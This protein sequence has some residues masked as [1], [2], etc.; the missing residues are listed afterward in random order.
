MSVVVDLRHR[1]VE[2]IDEMVSE[3]HR[4]FGL[5][6][7]AETK[8]H[9]TRVRAATLLS[10]LR[11]RIEAGEEGE[12]VDWWEWYAEKFSRTGRSRK[13]AE[14]L[15]RWVATGDPEGAHEAEKA[16]ARERMR[17]VRGANVRSTK[18]PEA[19]GGHAPPDDEMPT[20]EEADESWQ[21]DVYDHA[22]LLVERMAES[23]RRK[24]IAHVGKPIAA[25]G[26]TV[27]LNEQ[28]REPLAQSAEYLGIPAAEYIDFLLQLGMAA[29]NRK[30]QK[31]LTSQISW[32]LVEMYNKYPETFNVGSW[33]GSCGML[34][35]DKLRARYGTVAADDGGAS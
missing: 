30:F 34:S 3:I 2:T 14:K 16:E 5:M 13:D 31:G 10:K 25:S 29:F 15:M 12:G 27:T 17:K 19:A 4:Q 20:E 28:W 35:I 11:K 7:D 26:M 18:T 9:N 23:T 22:C 21:E 24:F 6:R 32:W 1:K 8:S 33:E